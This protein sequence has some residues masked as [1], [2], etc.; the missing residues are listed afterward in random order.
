VCV[1]VY[2][3]KVF[4]LPCSFGIGSVFA[5]TKVLGMK[6]EVGGSQFLTHHFCVVELLKE[7]YPGSMLG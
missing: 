5:G 6:A 2:A 7:R 4:F 1:C 3:Y